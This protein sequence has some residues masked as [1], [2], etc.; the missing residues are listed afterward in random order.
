MNK[1]VELVHTIY[2]YIFPFSLERLVKKEIMSYSSICDVGCGEGGFASRLISVMGRK[3]AKFVGCDIYAPFIHSAKHAGIY[4]NL[5]MCD[6][7]YLPFKEK[8]FDVVISINSIEHIPKDYLYVDNIEKL[9]KK[10]VIITTTR[11]YLYSKDWGI[12]TQKHLCGY[13]IEEFKNRGYAVYGWESRIFYL[14]WERIP[15]PFNL[16]FSLISHLLTA[17][18]YN[19]LRFANGLLCVKEMKGEETMNE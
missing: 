2:Y 8:S 19:H 13:E 17:L 7:R 11:G 14:L 10:R 5:V 18:T 9:A 16:A 4:D 12:P 3:G 15:P 1:F 6:I